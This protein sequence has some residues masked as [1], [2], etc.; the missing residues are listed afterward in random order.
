MIKDAK[1]KV[2]V[3]PEEA[4]QEPFITSWMLQNGV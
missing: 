3:L 2:P 4:V 1:T